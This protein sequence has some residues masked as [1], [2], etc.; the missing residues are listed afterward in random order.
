MVLAHV[1]AAPGDRRLRFDLRRPVHRGQ[2]PRASWAGRLAGDSL[3]RA[4]RTAVLARDTGRPLADR[5]GRTHKG[6]A[7]AR[8]DLPALSLLRGAADARHGRRQRIFFRPRPNLDGSLDRGRR[9]VGECR[10]GPGPHFRPGWVSGTGYL[11][12][13]LGNSGWV[14]DVGALG[15]RAVTAPQVPRRNSILCAAGGWNASCSAG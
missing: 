7:V 4:G 13:R 10:F 11:G 5:Y 9:N 6:P 8:G 3:R 2:T 12:C 14:V 1:W 15:F